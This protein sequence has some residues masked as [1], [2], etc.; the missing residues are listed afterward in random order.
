M[1]DLL[2]VK[3]PITHKVARP[4]TEMSTMKS[5]DGIAAML[6]YVPTQF[7][8]TIE[9]DSSCVSGNSGASEEE[10][11]RTRGKS[12]KCDPIHPHTLW[13]PPLTVLESR[14]C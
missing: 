12:E 11:A 14:G 4:T 7:P 10:G 9:R 8:E 1:V 3:L 5:S 6:S 2:H 13:R